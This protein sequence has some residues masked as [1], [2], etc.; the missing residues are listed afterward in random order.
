[1]LLLISNTFSVCFLRHIVNIVNNIVNKRFYFI[2]NMIVFHF[3]L[4]N[5]RFTVVLF[6]E[7]DVNYD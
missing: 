1:M 7:I 6:Y 2:T 4:M 5:R 3:S